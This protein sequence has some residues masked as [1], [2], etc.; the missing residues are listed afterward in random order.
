MK[1]DKQIQTDVLRELAYNP[2]V[3]ETHIGV[4]VEDGVVT[5]SGK[6]PSFAEKSAAEGSV[7]RV[8][9]VKAIVEKIEVELPGSLKRSDA[10]IAQAAIDALAWNVQVPPNS[11]KVTVE[12]GKLEL[13]GEV[14]WEFQKKAAYDSVKNLAGISWIDDAIKI[15]SRINPENVKGKIEEALKR[16]ATR[17]ASRIK[18][19]AEGGKVILTGK[20]RSLAEL[21][22]ASGAAWSAPGVSEVESRLE[23]A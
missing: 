5:L 10:D 20:V 17:E 9:G 8:E 7:L 6:V 4:S 14:S 1:S 11:V 15:R 23:V 13:S 3:T 21:R 22:D 18:I 16:A 19:E 12:N 2:S